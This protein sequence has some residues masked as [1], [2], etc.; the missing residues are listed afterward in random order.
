MEMDDMY[1]SDEYEYLME[2]MIENNYVSICG[3]DEDGEPIYKMTKDLIEDYPEIFEAHM[4]VT[5]EL[6]F[7]V[8]Q[9]GYLEMT[10]TEDGEW[11]IIPTDVTLNYEEI[12]D[13]TKDEKL[14]LW[15]ISEM[16]KRESQ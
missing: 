12:E 2:Y 15:E 7:S 4:E 13:L 14:L 5:N 1:S 16:K 10:M 11:L 8:W 3:L 9:K 6:V